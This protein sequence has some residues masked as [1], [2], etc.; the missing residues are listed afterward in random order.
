MNTLLGLCPAGRSGNLM[1]GALLS[2]GVPLAFLETELAKLPIR[3]YHLDVESKEQLGIPG[4]FCQVIVDGNPLDCQLIDMNASI[5][6]ADYS[7]TLKR[8][9]KLALQ[10]WAQALAYE[11]NIAVDQ[12]VFPGSDAIKG[13]VAIVGTMIALM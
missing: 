8:R 2:Y 9:A 7:P 12:V 3:G 10:H 1:F 6:G 5:D 11:D 4:I 13:M